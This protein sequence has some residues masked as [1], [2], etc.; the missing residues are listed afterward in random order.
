MFAALSVD[1]RVED[2]RLTL[3]AVFTA[4]IQIL[5]ASIPIKSAPDDHFT[6]RPHYRVTESGFGCVDRG[7]CGPGI[8][9]R[10]VSPASVHSAT[11]SDPTPDDHFGANPH[12]GLIAS[13]G[14]RVAG[15]DRGPSIRK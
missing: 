4:G 9:A 3:G 12:G 14:R 11:G 10:I 7:H 8:C 2:E 15:T 1:L 5:G 6:A 13:C